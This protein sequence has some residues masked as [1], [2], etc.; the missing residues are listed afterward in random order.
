MKSFI[1]WIETRPITESV[2]IV[3]ADYENNELNGIEDI[4]HNITLKLIMP[5]IERNL[6]EEDRKRVL[7]KGL[8]N[9]FTPDGSHYSS[10]HNIINFYTDGFESILDN[11]LNGIQYYLKE[12]GVSYNE[13]KTERSG[14]FNGNVVRIEI[15]NFPKSKDP[16]PELNWSNQNAARIFS[17]VLK[18]KFRVGAYLN[19]RELLQ[20]ISNA[21]ENALSMAAFPGSQDGNITNVGLSKDDVARRLDDLEK[22]ARWAMSK[23]YDKLAVY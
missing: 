10:G 9:V 17:N 19:I 8:Y 18:Y 22:L 15:T 23:D 7:N 20:R 12:M 3:V 1:E 21:R 14:M 16:A 4:C 13:F 11:V 6:S 2:S 5:V